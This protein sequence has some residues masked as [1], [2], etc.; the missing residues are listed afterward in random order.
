M[1]QIAVSSGAAR[2][3][4]VGDDCDIIV[5][6]VLDEMIWQRFYTGTRSDLTP[7]DRFYHGTKAQLARD[8]LILPGYAANFGDPQRVANHVYFSATLDAAIW[9]AELAR[10]E[11]PGHIY[12]VEPTGPFTDDPNLTDKKFPGNQTK[13]YRSREAVRIISEIIDWQ[14]HAS[15]VL[16]VM[17]DGIAKRDALDTNYIDD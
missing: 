11:T 8:D 12:I 14:G 3:H 7:E 1:Q 10:G 15:D 16:Q 17:R 5:P 2:Q 6:E 13:S 4:R 9:G